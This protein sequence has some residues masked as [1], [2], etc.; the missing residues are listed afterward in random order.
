MKDSNRFEMLI[1]I[2]NKY[3][4]ASNIQLYMYT[5]ISANAGMRMFCLNWNV[6]F[7]EIQPAFTLRFVNELVI[8]WYGYNITAPF[9][10][11]LTLGMIFNLIKLIINNN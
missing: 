7:K 9:L 3:D 8:K 6:K 10:N 11:L 5:L 4:S 1:V 2:W